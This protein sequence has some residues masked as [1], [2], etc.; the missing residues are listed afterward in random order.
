MLVPNFLVKHCIGI[1]SNNL[2]QNA[3][4]NILFLWKRAF[5]FLIDKMLT[6]IAREEIK[7]SFNLNFL[8]F[9]KKAFML[10]LYTSVAYALKCSWLLLAPLPG[11][12]IQK[13]SE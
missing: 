2:A 6:L 10:K 7:F 4:A 11:I 13:V 9:S 5:S 3:T 1:L 12:A 8:N